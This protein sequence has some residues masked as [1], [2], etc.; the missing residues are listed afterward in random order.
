MDFL[1]QADFHLSVLFASVVT[2]HQT[3]TQPQT[4][5]DPPPLC[6]L[7][8]IRVADGSCCRGYIDM[9]RPR[10]PPPPDG[11]QWLPC[12]FLQRRLKVRPGTCLRNNFRQNQTTPFS[13][14]G[15][16]LLTLYLRLCFPQMHRGCGSGVGSSRGPALETSFSE[17]HL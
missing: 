9:R 10:S 1:Q 8:V 13:G 15:V 12:T 11:R 17:M 4:P 16:H 2:L 14:G 5:G 7:F 3:L 6:L